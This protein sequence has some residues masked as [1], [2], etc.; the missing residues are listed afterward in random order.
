[1]GHIVSKNYLKLQKRLDRFAQSAPESEALFKILEV[2]FSKEEAGLVSNLPIKP[3]NA[4]KMAKRWKMSELETIKVLDKL[5][6]KGLLMDMEHNGQRT[7]LLLPTMAGFFEYSLMRTDGKFDRKILSELFYQ[8]INQEENFMAM[9]FGLGVSIARTFVHEDMVNVKDKTEILDYEK[10]TH[11]INS[12]SAISVGTCYCRH[13]ME[14][15][16]KACSMPQDV[17]LTFNTS[18]KSLIKNKIAKE[19]TKVKAHEI[20]KKC[21]EFG[22]VQIGDNV[23]NNVNWI[24]NCCGCC[25]EALQGYKRTGVKSE[26]DTNFFTVNQV[27]KCI[28]C[29]VC[30]KKCPVGAISMKE[31]DGKKYAVV[32]LEKCLGCGVCV[33]FCPTKSLELKRK[34]ELNFTPK[35]SFERCTLNAIETGKIGDYIFDNYESWTQEAFRRF[36]KI[37]FSLKPVKRIAISKNLRSRFL[38]A[39]EKGSKTK[40]FKK[41]YDDGSESLEGKKK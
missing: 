29:G 16:G 40:I 22:L 25:C 7:F 24:C 23:K 10:S 19:I 33:R 41:L 18:A 20:L 30:V 32:N 12:A 14:H 27:D 39:L 2:L 37:I 36:F 26:F 15:V 4:A 1:M 34:T 38:T 6:D 8:Y 17:C 11:I 31:K 13:K 21:M 3:F 28:G 5:A 9:L 35:D